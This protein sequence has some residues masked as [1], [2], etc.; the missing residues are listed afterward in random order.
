MLSLYIINRMADTVP[1]KEKAPKKEKVVKEKVVK[2][3]VVKE[4]APKKEKVLKKKEPVVEEPITTSIEETNEPANVFQNTMNLDSLNGING[5]DKEELKRQIIASLMKT[6]GTMELFNSLQKKMDTNDT[7]NINKKIVNVSSQ[8]VHRGK[9]YYYLDN[10]NN[11]NKDFELS[12][13]RNEHKNFTDFKVSMFLSKVVLDCNLPFLEFF[14]EMDDANRKLVF[15]SFTLLNSDFETKE[16]EERLFNNAQEI[17]ENI[18]YK[19][20]QE[21]TNA[22]LE[23]A[24]NAYKGYAELYD[25][26]IGK[27]VIFPV[28]DCTYIKF[29]LKK[30]QLWS[31][32]DEL[33][34]EQHIYHYTIERNIFFV[35]INNE[36]LSYIKNEKGDQVTFPCCLYLVKKTDDNT[37]YEN[38]YLKDDNTI[39]IVE[40][41]IEH[42]IF[43][44]QH[45][46]TTDPIDT[47]RKG[48]MKRYAAFLDNS[49]YFL[50]VSVPLQN[51]D[52]DGDAEEA[53]Y[54]ENVKT[55]KDYSSI[56]FFENNKQLW[57]VSDVGRYSP[58]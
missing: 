24:K 4:K 34:N 11:L 26:K 40:D 44:T 49:L 37:D 56:Y 14:V 9:N 33:L 21:Y 8:Y 48:R 5:I 52:L 20:F 16:G 58:L 45:F 13:A 50:N 38:V 23:Q 29:D 22:D 28:F 15:P 54:D 36:F 27:N 18:C 43:G 3:K 35:F 55:Y 1:I 53:D 31:V 46:F 25:D 47:D 10:E 7:E 19:Q 17:F 39:S 51:M 12:L 41:K 30:N 2:E 32:L 57:C 6:P 42:S